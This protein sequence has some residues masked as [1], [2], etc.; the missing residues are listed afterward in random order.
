MRFSKD[1]GGSWS[2]EIALQCEYSASR[3][4][5]YLRMVQRPYGKLVLIYYWNN[6]N[7]S[8]T[9]PYRHIAYTIFGPDIDNL[10]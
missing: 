6:A 1:N 4:V 2:D 7:K 5:G 9:E 8:I 10:K 3:D